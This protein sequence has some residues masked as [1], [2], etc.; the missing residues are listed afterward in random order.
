MRIKTLLITVL[1]CF[2]IIPSV[3]FAI[4]AN[5]QMNSIALQNYTDAAK[6]E[7]TDHIEFK[8]LAGCDLT[9]IRSGKKNDR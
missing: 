1:T 7:S 8:T 3:A 4:V 5:V 9:G 6:D 2:I